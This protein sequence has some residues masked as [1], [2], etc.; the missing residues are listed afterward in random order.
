MV[1][2]GS[3]LQQLA[4]AAKAGV[5]AAVEAITYKLMIQA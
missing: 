1:S 5:A 3:S 2:G 4:A